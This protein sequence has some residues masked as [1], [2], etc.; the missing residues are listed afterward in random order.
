MLPAAVM[1]LY[2][3][4]VTTQQTINL[5]NITKHDHDTSSQLDSFDPVLNVGD[6]YAKCIIL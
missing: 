1:L 6:D 3:L 4:K 5:D 2:C